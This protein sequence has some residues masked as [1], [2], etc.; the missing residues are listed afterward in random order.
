MSQNEETRSPLPIWRFAVPLLFQVGLILALPA[1]S[2]YTHITGKTVILQ[3]IPV[4]PYDPLRGYSQT[5]SYDI[6]RLENLRKLPG[7]QEIKKQQKIT[8]DNYLDSS[9]QLYV[10][11][12]SPPDG[13]K[14][15]P[16]AWKPVRVSGSPP[17]P[18]PAN[19]IALKGRGAGN[20]IR[21]GLETYYFP[22]SQQQEI[23]QAVSQAQ[24]G[25]SQLLVMEIKVDKQGNGVPVSLWI[26]DRNYRF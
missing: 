26:R 20:S 8:N 3:T 4:D 22:E 17:T 18:L 13:A 11:L 16:L 12:E 24:R 1:Q 19:Q 15:P 9:T 23:N 2:V 21:Y 5:L 7:W 6:S 25:R 14:Q 10:V